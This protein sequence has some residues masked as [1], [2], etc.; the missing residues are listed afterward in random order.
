M[1]VEGGYLYMSTDDQGDR[2]RILDPTQE[3]DFQAVISACHRC[4][5]LNL[6]TV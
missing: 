1:C 4:W 2:K 5:E 6:G 3:L